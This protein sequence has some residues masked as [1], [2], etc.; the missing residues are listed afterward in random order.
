MH[1]Y[2]FDLILNFLARLYKLQ[3]YTYMVRSADLSPYVKPG[4]DEE[5]LERRLKDSE[6]ELRSKTGMMCHNGTE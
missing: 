2:T 1:I 4:G 3:V 5:V 6:L